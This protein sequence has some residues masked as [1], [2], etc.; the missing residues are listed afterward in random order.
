MT[1]PVL[2][3]PDSNREFILETNAF[4]QGLGA[5]LSQQDETVRLCV[6]A[7]GSQSL[8]PSERSMHNYSSAKLELLVLQGSV[9]EKFCD[10]LLGSKFHMNTDNSPVAYVRESKLGASQIWWLSEL[11]LFDFTIHYL[12]G[13]SN[14]AISALSRHHH[15]EEETK[16]ERGSD[17]D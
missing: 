7:Y 5:V 11:A 12:T 13:R 8:C 10:Y 14:K 3:Y 15:K 17:C 1:T 2:G 9:M 4:L 16:I 6:I